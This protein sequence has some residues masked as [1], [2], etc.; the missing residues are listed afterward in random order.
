MQ[1]R[2]L[3]SDRPLL[4]TDEQRT[5]LTNTTNLTPE[6]IGQVVQPVPPA[7]RPAHRP[8]QDE[9]PFSIEEVVAFAAEHPDCLVAPMAKPAA[10]RAQN[11]ARHV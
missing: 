11:R 1:S 9:S 5:A 8:W 10:S 4:D 6:I 2:A 3:A 7:R